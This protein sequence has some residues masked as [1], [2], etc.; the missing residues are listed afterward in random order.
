MIIW[1]DKDSEFYVK[2]YGNHFSVQ[3]FSQLISFKSDNFILDVGCGGGQLINNIVINDN[4]S[5]KKFRS[6]GIDLKNHK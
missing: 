6:I 1:N 2:N 4:K 3:L 5:R